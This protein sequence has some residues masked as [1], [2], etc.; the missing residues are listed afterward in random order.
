[1]T[2]Y[3]PLYSDFSVKPLSVINEDFENITLT[4]KT[5]DIYLLEVGYP[6]NI[7]LESSNSTQAAFIEEIFKQ[8][9]LYANRIKLINICWLHDRTKAD[10]NDF[11]NYYGIFDEKFKAHLGSLGIRTSYDK[12]KELYLKLVEMANKNGW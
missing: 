5:K 1:M 8:W 12:D 11:C 2:T 10:V 9:N 4:Y 7:T 6:S 3:Y